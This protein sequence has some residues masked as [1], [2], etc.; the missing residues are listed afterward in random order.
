MSLTAIL[1]AEGYN[2]RYKLDVK[3]SQYKFTTIYRAKFTS[4]DE[5]RTL[6]DQISGRF[7][8]MPVKELESGAQRV[9]RKIEL[10]EYNHNGL[11]QLIDPNIF[12]L[13]S[14]EYILDPRKGKVRIIANKTFDASDAM[15]MVVP[16]PRKDIRVGDTWKSDLYF[17]LR[18][19][20]KNA[21]P[22]QGS[23]KLMDVQGN[24][25]RVVGKYSAS[26]KPMRQFNYQGQIKWDCEFYFNLSRGEIERG[27]FVVI[28]KYFSRSKFARE[29]FLQSQKKER[30]GYGFHVVSSFERD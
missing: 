2:L 17:N 6:D 12:N 27:K 8:D 5:I 9:E 21:I 25:A 1:R 15:E 13:S 4:P 30:I 16:F 23:F 3:G 29:F 14:Y 26:V 7:E 24:I 20:G 18:P 11:K 19:E 10:D 22:L 28:F